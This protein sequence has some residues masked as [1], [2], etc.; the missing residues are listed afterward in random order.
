MFRGIPLL[1]RVSYVNFVD[2]LTQFCHLTDLDY[3]LWE[4][5]NMK[6]LIVLFDMIIFICFVSENILYHWTV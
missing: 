4:V 5:G 6:Q 1:G 2:N 3:F